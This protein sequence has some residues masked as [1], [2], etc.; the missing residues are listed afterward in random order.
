L[1]FVPSMLRAFLATPGV[2]ACRSLERVICSGEALAF[3]LQ[4]S[5]YRQLGARL[6]NL[7]GPTEAAIDV[8]WWPCARTASEAVVPIGRPVDNTHLEVRDRHLRPAPLGVAGELLIGGVQLARGYL[9]R[10]AL[11]AER[12]IPDPGGSGERLY[13]TGDLARY[14][15]DGSIEFLGRLDHQVKLRG[16]RIEL[17]E[18]EAVLQ[19]HPGVDD[20]AV[21]SRELAS[22]D[23]NLVAYI[24]PDSATALPVHRLARLESEGRLAGHERAE[25]PN[26]L[27]VVH[28]NRGETA[29]LYQEL[30]E[31]QAYKRHGIDLVPGACVFD[32]G[33]NIGLF[34]LYAAQQWPGARV[35]AFEPLPPLFEVLDLN[36]DLYG[37]P[38]GRFAYGLGSE[39]GEVRFEYFPHAS[40]LSGRHVDGSDERQTVKRF[41][42]GRDE[43]LS[44]REIEE[45]LAERLEHETYTCQVKPL[46]EVIREE[47]IE[48]IDL[49]KVDV[50]KSELEV[51]RGIAASDWPKIRQVVVEVHDQHGRMEAIRELLARHGFE[52]VV[53]QDRS[54]AGTELFNLYARRTAASTRAGEIAP[55][56]P[57]RWVNGDRLRADVQ[58]HALSKL[59]DYMAPQQLVWLDALPLSANG[60]LDRRALERIATPTLAEDTPATVAAP[61]TPTEEL[62]CGLWMQLLDREQVRIFD[63]FFDLGG[64]SLLATQAISQVRSLLAVEMSVR[65]LFQ[66]PSIAGFAE[67]IE[68]AKVAGRG[69]DLPPIEPIARDRTLP[70]PLSFAQERLWFLDQLEPDSAAY[71]LAT[72][73]RFSGHIELAVLERAL[74]EVV[75][76]H[77]VL[78]TRFVRHDGEPQQHIEPS[79]PWALPLVDLSSLPP[80]SRAAEA[81]RLAIAEARRPFDLGAGHLLRTVAVRLGDDEHRLVVLLHHIVADGWSTGVLVREVT[82]L[83]RALSHRQLSPLEPLP[84]QYADFAIWQRR[85]LT[86]EALAPQIAYWKGQLTGAPQTLALPTDRPR[87]LAGTAQGSEQ[88]WALNASLS[89]DLGEL[90]R[91]HGSTL[92]MTLAAALQTLLQRYS[93]QRDLTLGTPVANRRHSELEGLVGLF[94]NTLVV[95]GRLA[96]DP[97]FSQ[98]LGR[99]RATLLEAYAHQDLP[100]EQLVEILQPERLLD[101]TPLFQVMLTFQSTPDEPLELPGL[102]IESEELPTG[103]TKLDLSLNLEATPAGLRGSWIWASQLFDRTTILRLIG[104]FERLL[105]GIVARPATRLSQLPLLSAAERAQLVGEW[106]SNPIDL[107]AGFPLIQRLE[108][109]AA[110]WPEAV[111]VTAITADGS[112]TRLMYRELDQRAEALAHELRARGVGPEGLVAV[113][114]GR[115]LELP[116]TLFAIL[117]AGGAFLPL[118]LTDP[119]ERTAAILADARPNLLVS[120]GPLAEAAAQAWPEL[121][122]IELGPDDSDLASSDLASSDPASSA[123]VSSKPSSR[124]AGAG[125]NLA[126]VIYT[127]GSS[128]R[129]KGVMVSHGSLLNYLLWVERDLLSPEVVHLPL[130]SRVAF[131]ASLKQL[132]I[133]LLRGG[134]VQIPDQAILERPSALL[135]L[136]D[137][138]G[139]ALN[140]VPSLWE[141]LLQVLE[142]GDAELARGGPSQLLLGGE[143]LSP[144]LVER[145]RA[146]LPA[147]SL[148]NLYGPTE[149]TANASAATVDGPASVTLGRPVIGTTL[150]ALGHRLE[151]QPAGVVGELGIGG[152]GVARG[153]LGRPRRTAE[154]FVPDPWCTDRNADL[155][156][157]GGGGRLYLTG[158]LVRRRADGSLHY[159][160]RRDDQVKVRGFRV[161]LGEIEAALTALPEVA[162]AAVMLDRQAAGGERLVAYVVSSTSQ[163]SSTGQQRDGLGEALGERLPRY[164]VPA[165][166]VA[167]D[168]LPRLP[169]GKIDRRRLAALPEVKSKP[170]EA[171]DARPPSSPVEEIL[172]GIWCDLFGLDRVGPEDD[173]FALGGH[174]LLA[175]QVASRLRR[176][177]GI[178]LPLRRLFQAS[179][180]AALTA[181]VEE[182]RSRSTEA[183]APAFAPVDRTG[184]LPL[185]FAQERLWLLHR[186]A[187]ESPAYNLPNFVTLDGALDIPAL[188]FGLEQLMERHEVLRSV[189]PEVAGEPVARLL[190][191]TPLALPVVDLA[192]LPAEARRSEAARLGAW[193]A[194]RPFDL[195]RGPLVRASLIRLAPRQ[196]QLLLTLH[197]ILSDGWSLPILIRE[198]GELY[199]AGR[200]RQTPALSPLPIQYVDFAAGQRQW[201]RG[202][203]LERQLDFW[204]LQLQAPPSTLELPSDRARPAV[205]SNHG[206]TT[207]VLLPTPLRDRLEELSQKQGVTLFMTLLAVFQTLLSRLSGQ[208]DLAIGTPIAGRQRLE[209]EALI[210]LFINTLVLRSNLPPKARFTEL[211]ERAREVALEAYAH[212]DLPFER[213]VEALEPQRNRSQTPLFQVMLILQNAPTAALQLPGLSVRRLTADLG[214]SKF[215]LTL[216]IEPTD[217]GLAG[218][219]EYNRDLFDATT[220]ARW[221]LQLE[222]LSRGVA[223]DPTQRFHDLPLLAR[224]ERHQLL[225]EWNDPASSGVV[226]CLHEIVDAQT[227][228]TPETVAVVSGEH[229]LSYLELGRRAEG[230]AGALAER[231]VGPEIV[232]GLCTE[233][234]VDLLVGLLGILRAGGAYLPLDPTYPAQRL[235]FMLADA[236]APVLVTRAALLEHLPAD[237]PPALRLDDLGPSPRAQATRHRPGLQNLAYVIY[238]S[239]STGRPKGVQISHRALMNFLRSMAQRPGLSRSDVLVAVTSLSFDIAAL[240]LFLPLSMGARVV[241]A[242][243]EEAADGQ[244]LR[245]LLANAE[246]TVLQATPATWQMLEETS[247][248]PSA[249]FRALCGGEA[250]PLQLAA[251]LRTQST[252]AWNLYGPTETTIWSTAWEIQNRDRVAIGR[253][254]AETEVYL[255]DG[256]IDPVP[257]GAV[258]E[259]MIGST[260]LAR[261]YLDRPGRTAAAF[262][263]H[264]FSEVP[265]RRFYRT[266]DLAR[267]RADGSLECLGRIDHQVKVR[268]FRIELGEI[269]ARLSKAPGIRQAAVLALDLE[270]P[271]DR[272]TDRRLVACVVP[273]AQSVPGSRALRDFLLQRLPDHMAPSVFVPFDELP[274]TPNGKLDRGALGRAALSRLEANRLAQGTA[275]DRPVVAPRNPV[276]ELLVGL[277][278]DVLGR[279]R[280]GIDQSFFDLGGHS[281]LAVKLLTRVRDHFDVELSLKTVFESPTVGEL[282]TRIEGR[283]ATQ[284]QDVAALEPQ[285]WKDGAPLSFAQEQMWFFAQLQDE[286]QL[287]NL[288]AAFRLRGELSLPALRV[289]LAEIARRHQVLRTRIVLREDQPWQEVLPA[290]IEKPVADL[291]GLGSVTRRAEVERLVRQQARVPFELEK[292]PMLRLLVLQLAPQDHVLA[293]TLHHIAAD[294]WSFRLFAHE[295]EVLYAASLE[296]GGAP[297]LPALPVQYFDYA[298]WQ[299]RWLDSDSASRELAY[300]RQALGGAPPLLELPADRPRSAV[301]SFR[302]AH[303][304]IHLP[305]DLT[306]RL[307]ELGR[308]QGTTPFITLLTAFLGLLHRWSGS[309][310]LVVG[311]PMAH[312]PRRE[313]EDLI[314]L[315]LNMVALRTDLAGNPSFT[316]LLRRVRTAALAAYAHQNL[317]FERLVEELAPARSPSYTPV[318]QV[319]F[320]FQGNPAQPLQLAGL[321][322]EPLLS[323]THTAR[324]DLTLSM[325]DDPAGWQ[326]DLEYNI[327]LF[328]PSTLSH[329][330][331]HFTSLLAAAAAD[332]E[333]ALTELPLL[334]PAEHHQLLAEWPDTQRDLPTTAIHQLFE[335]RV[336]RTP[337]ATAL[338][339]GH[340]RL[341]YRELDHEAEHMAHRLRA[342][343]V[344][345]EVVV[346][347]HLQRGPE[348]V[349]ALLGV[350]KAGGAY[351]PLDPEYP[352]DRLAFM[353]RDAGVPVLITA[354]APRLELGERSVEQ[355]AVRWSSQDG[356]A[357]E[358]SLTDP[359]AARATLD[360][361]AYVIYT[362]GSTG[363]P[364]GVMIC[365]R[366]VV[367]FFVGMD[368]RLGDPA[369][370][371]W[372]A[373]TS[374]SFDISVLEIFWTLTR[375]A[376]VVIQGESPRGAATPAANLEAATPEAS[377]TA[378]RPAGQ[379]ATT[380]ATDS[381]WMDF[382]LFYFASAQ[383][384]AADDKYR[385]LL[386]GAKAADRLGF[387]GVWTPERHFHDFGGLY[388]NPATTGAAVAAI[389]ERVQIRAG[390]V[391]LPLHHPVRVAEEWSVVDNISGGRAA[392]SFASGWQPNDFVFAPQRYA[393]RK[394]FMLREIETVRRL[395]RGESVALPGVDGNTSRVELFP[396]PVQAELPFWLTAGGN[397]ETFRA[398]GAM[399][400]RLL[401]HL[402]GQSLDELAQKIAIYR[403]AWRD[404]GHGPGD[405]HVSLM[406][407]T[408]VGDDVDEIR[409]L[410]RQPFYGYLRSSSGL[411]ANLMRSRGHSGSLEDFSE[412]AIETVLKG[413]FERYFET[414]SLMGSPETCLRMAE[415]LAGIGVDEVACLIDFGVEVDAVLGS[416]EQLAEVQEATRRPRRS[417]A[418]SVPEELARHRVSHLQCTPSMA[419]LLVRDPAAV[420]GLAGLEQLL[421]GGEALPAELV[422]ELRGKTTA[423]IHNL[424]GPTET[425]IWSAAWQLPKSAPAIS[426]G[427]EIANTRITVCDRQLRLTPARTPGQ[428]YIAGEGLA[429]G[430]LGRPGLT[431]ERFPPDPFSAVP[432]ERLYATGDMARRAPHGELEFL[433]RVDHQLKLHGYRIEPAEIEGVLRQHPVVREAVVA[434]HGEGE[435]L[436][437]VAYVVPAKKGRAAPIDPEHKQRLLAGHQ[438]FTLPNG[439]TVAHYNHRQAQGLF[440]EVFAE[441]PYLRHGIT[442][443]DGDTI[444]DVG[445][446]AGFFSLFASQV[447]QPAKIYAFEPIPDNCEL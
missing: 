77:E 339:F 406:L 62:L 212:Q 49:L 302:G 236:A 356:A 79:Q 358:R 122:R 51:L 361:L 147:A 286:V 194:R 22:G 113:A 273:R 24:V 227:M 301:M 141:T 153:Y 15:T 250:L 285:T 18:I 255:L 258:G 33:A 142:A 240:E 368:E 379:P 85:W 160:G 55:A 219:I 256:A 106:A 241:V 328:D 151:L 261:G 222:T 197:H 421:L 57:P 347:V 440:D 224:A 101:Q 162:E 432:G 310:D 268:G 397:P 123:P 304:P 277:W 225:A 383:S 433:G 175:T 189:F 40:I 281:L 267:Y 214:S 272:W 402:L 313:T 419:K 121:P 136:V 133:P 37:I 131:D 405:G 338:L 435:D 96:G 427:R 414:S 192:A 430:Y 73:L 109:S 288:P 169:G 186:L 332:P 81:R 323:T 5:F 34:A 8:T 165:T 330:A 365:H 247:W 87:T 424:Y 396:K 363:R 390:S 284:R 179:T 132:F 311:S 375:G 176:L 437:L 425:T 335:Q 411:M 270:T 127:S 102:E 50:E 262:L 381:Q 205:R 420:T 207:P 183:E 444:F 137:R 93:G 154:S 337:T 442:Y 218:E 228:R 193:A 341:T 36:L 95:R 84:V 416:L 372:L 43:G 327:A 251:R 2:A 257:I 417:S 230:L 117:K 215:D 41:L 83:Y 213:L 61:R 334:S 9:G 25:L 48:R 203:V 135:A 326:G 216:A 67:Q 248:Q 307:S 351:L 344:G 59:P 324:F 436:R 306:R 352:S 392:I 242:N 367:N 243:E 30:F 234:S 401:T 75:R 116:I 294:G 149:A 148:A 318:F 72:N 82:T 340:Q 404:A 125:P 70:L 377:P 220:V 1:H 204:R 134:T 271:G 412:E 115:G 119:V 7:Y 38:G 188:R 112:E 391:V 429:R 260:G 161:E 217:E 245:R 303:Q 253:P 111:A 53:E 94:V 259:L 407:H 187:P 45:L 393:D 336:E 100:F 343:G 211:L 199:R 56:A 120:D 98:L 167:L 408:F 88:A 413:S 60:K 58:R 156:S 90:A 384:A 426:I 107:D 177:F 278:A 446:N 129:P 275:G 380:E 150:Y 139:A 86:T 331:N 126:Y 322:T 366:N 104:S 266:G 423:E 246:A 155:G 146:W 180:L 447:C 415:S 10:P 110:R 19:A 263:P 130:V 382:S 443:A 320:T 97:P 400:A 283:L 359:P 296:G 66:T 321:S 173:F 76:R 309:R 71:H 264:P 226:E 333:A 92:F 348:L 388:P 124:P 6:E 144:D 68:A 185:S 65:Q 4:E 78:R 291:S 350:L 89:E 42:L 287:Y 244:R 21:L 158:D 385:L 20:V 114:V 44:E 276:E 265:G 12:F 317:P 373:V 300:W 378:T 360:N 35:Y 238:T 140:C 195:A 374:M 445:A 362:S 314:G 184:D 172:A 312:R 394:D 32:V 46:S 159:V 80:P 190:P 403:E 399:G 439:M 128:G 292:G 223:N 182:A 329:F 64:H 210:G 201:L 74:T 47:G 441:R 299:R 249:G 171:R 69:V 3:E 370:K 269:E 342:R 63:S 152:A 279:Q 31:D 252:Q 170:P 346:G 181:V 376:T 254:I 99:T 16:F 206:A 178:E 103:A 143:A 386:E 232:V 387:A 229:H 14:R 409:E 398:A 163:R 28:K 297:S 23:S 290:R 200:D 202:E 26:G 157:T 305:S 196:H 118:D 17:G 237:R 349:I 345:R 209:T 145:T 298:A 168:E 308:R 280:V 355:L 418:L 353:V 105:R 371:T 438:S 221:A 389:T 316:A 52:V 39:R 91:A 357:S 13:R 166:F 315:F 295:L 293:A 138:P 239:G 431:A 54:L 29:F 233:R 325:W 428:L 354:K 422:T 208:Q 282:A 11:S 231:G 395:W 198:V 235:A 410:V 174:S 274:L 108:A 27:P 434:P 191:P 289:A 369:D 164:M 319:T 364:K